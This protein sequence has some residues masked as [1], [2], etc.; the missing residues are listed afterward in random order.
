MSIE[1]YYDIIRKKNPNLLQ[2]QYNPNYKSHLMDVPFRLLAIGPSGSG[3]TNNILALIHRMSGT[4]SK[5]IICC[6]SAGEPL[7]EYL[8]QQIPDGLEMHE[9]K[10]ADD[11]PNLPAEKTPTLIIFD[12]LVNSDKNIQNKITEYFIRGRKKDISCCYLTQ[13]Y[14]KTPKTIRQNCSYIMLKKLPNKND[15]RLILSEFSINNT[16]EELVKIY[17]FATQ[18]SPLDFLMIDVINEEYRYRKNFTP[19]RPI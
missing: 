5:I 9:I 14:F 19:I 13:S 6:R 3:K 15:L 12:D 10:T 18:G 2:K 1:N 4:F 11:I 17:K 7:Y 8:Q 16:M